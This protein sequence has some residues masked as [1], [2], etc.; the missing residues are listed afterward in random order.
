MAKGEIARFEQFL[1]L[2]QLMFSKSKSGLLLR[3]Q[4]ASISRKGLIL[5]IFYNSVADDFILT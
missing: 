1:L 4:K 5:S 2:S 3:R